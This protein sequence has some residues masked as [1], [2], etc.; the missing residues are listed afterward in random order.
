MPQVPGVLGI[1]R[2]A[3]D[4]LKAGDSLETRRTPRP[5]KWSGQGSN[6]IQTRRTRGSKKALR[7][8]N[9]TYREREGGLVILQIV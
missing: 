5:Q 9:S 2:M 7:T 3:L 4:K 1:V 6:E 8:Q